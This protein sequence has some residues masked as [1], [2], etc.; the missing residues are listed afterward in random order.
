MSYLL[1][2]KRNIILQPW[3]VGS[4][5]SNILLEGR[6][7]LL[8]LIEF[9]W[10]NGPRPQTDWMDMYQKL[11]AYRNQ[12]YTTNVPKKF[13][14]LGLWV[15]LQRRLQNRSRLLDERYSLLVSINFNWK[16]GA[17]PRTNWLHMYERLVEYKEE[18]NNA[19]VPQKYDLDTKLGLWV[20]RQRNT[21]DNNKL[22]DEYTSLLNSIGPY[23]DIHDLTSYSKEEILCTRRCRL[24]NNSRKNFHHNCRSNR[25]S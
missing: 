13:G 22:L 19:N 15:H 23:D 24:H 25:C 5:Y 1:H 4:T 14:S 8:E 11:I 2:T 7:S 21:Y 16:D 3:C 10:G 18:H 9:D 17:R 6:Y 12:H 20:M